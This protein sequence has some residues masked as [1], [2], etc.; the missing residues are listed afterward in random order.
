MAVT[1]ES[2][3]TTREA[4]TLSRRPIGSVGVSFG[5]RVALLLL[6]LLLLLKPPPPMS[7]ANR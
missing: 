5:G 6:L 2:H 4:R 7:T 3:S 1:N